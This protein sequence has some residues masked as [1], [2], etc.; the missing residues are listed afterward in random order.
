MVLHIHVYSYWLE[1]MASIGFHYFCFY[2]SLIA[3]PDSFHSVI[4]AKE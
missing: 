4:R 3:N 1:I 2:N